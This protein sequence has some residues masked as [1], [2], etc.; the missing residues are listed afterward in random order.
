MNLPKVLLASTA[1]ACA[2]EPEA[3]LLER[4]AGSECG[5]NV[6]NTFVADEIDDVLQKQLEGIP[7]Y[8]ETVIG[9]YI[10]VGAVKSTYRDVLDDLKLTTIS[11]QWHMSG[12]TEGYVILDETKVSSTLDN[13]FV[14]DDKIVAYSFYEDQYQMIGKCDFEALE[15]DPAHFGFCEGNIYQNCSWESDGSDLMDAANKCDLVGTFTDGRTLVTGLS[16]DGM[17][18]YPY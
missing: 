18:Y 13:G 10:P 9:T 12:T 14:C 7:D 15:G 8:K 3:L 1:I 2:P 5:V 16:K 11:V 4:E 17:N 6:Y